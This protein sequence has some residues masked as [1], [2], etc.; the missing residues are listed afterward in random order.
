MFKILKSQDHVD[1]DKSMQH[2]TLWIRKGNCSFITSLPSLSISP[3]DWFGLE[4]ETDFDFEAVHQLTVLRTLRQ[5]WINC[6]RNTLKDCHNVYDRPSAKDEHFVRNECTNN[7]VWITVWIYVEISSYW[8]SKRLW[9]RNRKLGSTD[10]L[11][12]FFNDAR[13]W[14]TE[15]VDGTFTFVWC[16]DRKV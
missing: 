5:L 6:L 10:S 8:S 4:T 2:R 14:S 9:M 13:G 16:T 12:E 1:D 7:D 3:V 15:D 11:G